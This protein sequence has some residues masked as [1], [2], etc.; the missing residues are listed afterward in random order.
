VLGRYPKVDDLMGDFGVVE[1]FRVVIF[2]VGKAIAC[3]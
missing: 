3:L 1:I 2:C